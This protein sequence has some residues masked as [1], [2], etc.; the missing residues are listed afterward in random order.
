MSVLVCFIFLLKYPQGQD[1]CD[2][3]FT[4]FHHCLPHCPSGFKTDGKFCFPENP[5]LVDIEFSN[6]NLPSP[7]KLD[8]D[9]QVFKET[10]N[11]AMTQSRGSFW[12]KKSWAELASQL[13]MAPFFTVQVWILVLEPGKILTES[14]DFVEIAS[15]GFE[16][17]AR[18]KKRVVSVV[19]ENNWTNFI[20][21]LQFLHDGELKMKFISNSNANDNLFEEFFKV[22]YSTLTI[23]S[24][25]GDTFTGFIY[26][27][28]IINLI[29][30]SLEAIQLPECDLMQDESCS[31]KHISDSKEELESIE[32]CCMILDKP[33]RKA[34]YCLLIFQDELRCGYETTLKSDFV[35]YTVDPT[36]GILAGDY[37]TGTFM[38][39]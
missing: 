4:Y 15:N 16:I 6:Q 27:F 18:Y 2:N 36:V 22:S 35:S 12:S 19:W 23:G 5:I 3:G 1:I 21:T 25:S 28:R 13:V 10:S 29:E 31:L 26:K 20:L 32:S 9:T 7:D 38:E 14:G 33:K 37:S 11:F 30:A 34:A 17:E 8:T 24:K 39:K